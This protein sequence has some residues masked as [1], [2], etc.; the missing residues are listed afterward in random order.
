MPILNVMEQWDPLPPPQPPSSD[1]ALRA[2]WQP[3]LPPCTL[4]HASQKLQR[5]FLRKLAASQ[6]RVLICTNNCGFLRGIFRFEATTKQLSIN[7]TN[8]QSFQSAFKTAIW[9]MNGHL[10]FTGHFRQGSNMNEKDQ[11]NYSSPPLSAVSLF[12]GSVTSGQ[13]LSENIEWKNPE[14]NN[15]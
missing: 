8:I 4:T 12:P 14:T 9:N 1:S 15:S 10:R 11:E 3:N 6:G 2:M 7:P 13:L 5:S